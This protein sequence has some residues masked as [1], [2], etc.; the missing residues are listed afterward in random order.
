MQGEGWPQG[1]SFAIGAVM[2]YCAGN[3]LKQSNIQKYLYISD[4]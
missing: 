4:M 2:A 3:K 1:G